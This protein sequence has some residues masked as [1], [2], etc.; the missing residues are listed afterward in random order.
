MKYSSTNEKGHK[1]KVLDWMNHRKTF[2]VLFL[3]CILQT[4]ST[5]AFSQTT[6][7]SLNLKNVSVEQALNQIEAKTTYRFLYNKDMVDVNHKVSIVCKKQS[8]SQTLDQ[9]FKGL[10][11][12]YTINGKQIVLSKIEKKPVSNTTKKVNGTITDEEGEPIIGATVLVEGESAGTITDVNGKFALTVPNYSKIKISY[13]GFESKLVSVNNQNILNISLSKSSNVLDEMVVIGFGTQ[14]KVNLTGSVASVNTKQLESRP[15]ANLSNALQGI[16]PGLNITQS[17]GSLE[18]RPTVN[19]R[20]ITTI[21]EGSSGSPLILID[22]MEGDINTVNPNDVD[23]IS[24]LKDAAASSIYGSRAPFGVIL[25]TTKKGEAG[26]MQINY[27]GNF[28]LH[29][30]LSLPKEMDSYTFA[31]YWNAAQENAG[32]GAF[33]DTEHMQRIKDFM[34][35][36]LGKNTDIVD[37]NNPT[38][39]G[40]GYSYGNDNVDWY[41]A[42]YKTSTPSQQHSLSATGGNEKLNYYI[43]GDYLNQ[44]GL[45]NLNQDTYKTYTLN[46]KINARLSKWASIIYT[47]R[48]TREDYRKPSALTDNLYY[49]LG[50]QGWPTLPLY[51]PNG[52]LFS[53]P[54]PALALRDGGHDKTQTDWNYQQLNLTLEPLTGWKIFA[55]LN[56]KIGD[57]FHHYDALPTYQHNVAGDPFLS[58][59]WCYSSLKSQVT[60]ESSRTNYFTPN[61]YSE[62]VKSFGKHNMK[63]MAGFQSELNNYR[64]F[65]ATRVGIMVPS[66][67]SLDLTSGTD[68]TGA[69]VAPTVGGSYTQWATQGVFGR[70]NYDY[71]GRYLVEVNLRHDGTSRFRAANRWKNFPS[72]SLG[73]NIAREKFW[74]PIEPI[75]NNFKLRAS[76]GS[77]GNQNTTSLYPTYSTMPVGIANGTW[78]VND[79]KPNTSASPALISTGMTWEMIKTINGG[80]DLGLFNNRLTSSFDYYVRYTNDMI[81]PAPELPA[82]LGTT[83]PRANNTDLKTNGFE[84]SVCWTDRLQNG[85]G[86]NISFVLSDS[87]TKITKYPNPTGNLSSYY[88]GQQYGEI[89]GYTTVGIAKTQNEMDAHLAALA[90]GGQNALGS[91]WEAG[92]IMYKDINNDGKID[93][94]A[95]TTHDHGDLSVI[96]NSQPRFNFGFNLSANWKGFDASAFLQGVAKRDYWQGS[97]YFFGASGE[98]VWW[99]TG[100]V[101]HK[102]YFRNDASAYGGLNLDAYYPRPLQGDKKNIECQTRYLQNAAYIRL[103]NLQLGYTIPAYLTQKALIQ[104]CRIYFSG[105]NILTGTKLSKIFDPETIGG[106]NAGNGNAYPLCKVYSAGL[107]VTF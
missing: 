41:R 89:W 90:N 59:Q 34:D 96:G 12:A 105:E 42:V 29:K 84:W 55:N 81:G 63:V 100:F 74:K 44:E 5:K 17:G 20:G 82:I 78:L 66:L 22:G 53:S 50:I 30:P 72:T 85:L 64:I 21:G 14:K 37:P 107:S 15:V 46:A 18:G 92:D 27:S 16:T 98:G 62:Y 77:L 60:E 43:S 1:L 51:D 83:V 35:G 33:F 31:N 2:M 102:D 45:M 26:K 28:R 56:Y 75:V 69:T 13:I 70:I 4:I 9:I 87:K 40:D 32:K 25:I 57:V 49:W 88:A 104:K 94:G 95:Y 86:Y 54:S 68:Y 48:F 93:W 7:L 58:V 106:G 11:I 39:W 91:H 19:I 23:N 6:E 3:C 99:A 97:A 8:V 67:P 103:K 65:S 61:I 52:Y 76:Y 38:M 73:W 24:V 10:D 79:A 47:A 71:D 80:V 36:K 101:Q